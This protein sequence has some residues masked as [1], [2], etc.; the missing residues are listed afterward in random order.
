MP[1]HKKR[2]YQFDPESVQKWLVETGRAEQTDG[3]VV[4]RTRA[5]IAAAVGVSVRTISDWC[6]DPTFPGKPGDALTRDGYFPESKIRD[7]MTAKG[8][9][10]ESDSKPLHATR[11]RHLETKTQLDLLKLQERRGE[12]VEVQ[13]VCR[14]LARAVNLA[15]QKLTPLPDI[16]MRMLPEEMD[17]RVKAEYY[18]Q[19]KRAIDDSYEAIAEAIEATTGDGGDDE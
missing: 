1:V 9:G 16:L 15:R 11:V 17:E 18:A 19:I 3:E 2:P 6:A 14:E 4:H 5:D 10:D 7:W 13:V 12:L 8:T